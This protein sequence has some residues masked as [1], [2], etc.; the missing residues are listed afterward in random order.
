MMVWAMT[1]AAGVKS[2]GIHGQPR[3][4]SGPLRESMR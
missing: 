4:P 1:M 3:L 2:P